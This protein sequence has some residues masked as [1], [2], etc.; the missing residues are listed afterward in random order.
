MFKINSVFRNDIMKILRA[1]LSRAFLLAMTFFVSILPSNAYA[2][3]GHR[4]PDG[5]VIQSYYDPID[6]HYLDMV[7]GAHVRKALK[8][9]REGQYQWAWT[10][11]LYTL[12]RVPNHPQSLLMLT[13]FSNDKK[14]NIVSPEEAEQYF[15]K[16]IEYTPEEPSTRSLYAYHLYRSEKFDE[17]TEQYEIALKLNPNSAEINYNLGLAYLKLERNEDALSRAREAYRLGHPLPG[18]KELLIKKGLWETPE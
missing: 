16:A 18:L 14:Q 5:V 7:T 3:K 4:T 15:R 2:G 13:N 1:P 11:I 6:S 8:R 10:D 12:H 17:A 9:Y